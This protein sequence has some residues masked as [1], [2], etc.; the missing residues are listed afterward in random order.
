MTGTVAW[1]KFNESA[2]EMTENEPTTEAILQILKIKVAVQ[3]QIAVERP[4]ENLQ[5]HPRIIV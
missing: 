1:C 2:K 5:R 4:S 3:A